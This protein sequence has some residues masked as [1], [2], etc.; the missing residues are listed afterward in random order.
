MSTFYDLFIA[1]ADE[2][3]KYAAKYLR[4]DT[5]DPDEFVDPLEEF[6]GISLQGITDLNIYVLL[7]L[8]GEKEPVSLTG[9]ELVAAVSEEEGPWLSRHSTKFIE[10]F[11]HL[12]D[13]P[14]EKDRL[15]QLWAETEDMKAHG[16]TAAEAR[17]ALD[18]LS[19]LAN[20]ARSEGKS[21]YQWTVV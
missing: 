2:A 5:Y 21:I 1:S 9:E 14:V 20:Q 17:Q 12:V 16:W 11:A 8:L 7:E 10:L 15:A 13:N 6:E 3:A 18:A 19:N 4:E